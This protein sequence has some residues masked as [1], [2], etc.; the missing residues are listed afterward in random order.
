MRARKP[1][2][3][4]FHGC[5]CCALLRRPCGGLNAMAAPASPSFGCVP[6]RPVEHLETAKMAGEKVRSGAVHH[7]ANRGQRPPW[8]GAQPAGQHRT[9]RRLLGGRD[10]AACRQRQ[11]RALL[12]LRK[13]VP[14]TEHLMA[15]ELRAQRHQQRRWQQTQ[16][17]ARLAPAGRLPRAAAAHRG[18]CTLLL[19]LFAGST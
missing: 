9:S 3:G 13:E 15:S 19:L 17:A 12:A 6:G 14:K 8:Q 2:P 11:G 4:I 5:P 10:A 7:A 16:P 18:M 1:P